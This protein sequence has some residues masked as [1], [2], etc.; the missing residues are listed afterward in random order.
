MKNGHNFKHHAFGIVNY[1][2]HRIC[3]SLISAVNL[4]GDSEEGR[5]RL[6]QTADVVLLLLN[7]EMADTSGVCY[8]S[9]H[10]PEGSQ[11][12]YR[13]VVLPSPYS[14]TVILVLKE[15]TLATSVKPKIVNQYI[16][17]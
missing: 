3:N 13:L 11:N 10:E 16:V 2:V 7:N 9:I 4:F 14:K 5:R 12:E 15:F 1:F 8:L 17:I 6:Y